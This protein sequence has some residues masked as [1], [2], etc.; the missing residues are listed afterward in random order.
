[1]QSRCLPSRSTG[2][3]GIALSALTSPLII[4]AR[5]PFDAYFSRL[6]LLRWLPPLPIRLTVSYVAA[7]AVLGMLGLPLWLL[8]R[9]F[10]AG[11]HFWHFV[12][13]GALAGAFLAFPINVASYGS[14]DFPYSWPD[15]QETIRPGFDAFSLFLKALL[16]SLIFWLVV[17][18][19]EMKGIERKRT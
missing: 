4:I 19:R 13:A 11:P 16:P 5:L 1:V 18:R 2:F 7:F 6:G 12:T 10:V 3:L 8:Y 14:P 17:Y 15:G 9:K